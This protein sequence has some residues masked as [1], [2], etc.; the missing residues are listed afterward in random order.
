MNYFGKHAQVDAL[1]VRPVVL[2]KGRTVAALYGLGNV[3]DERLYRAFVEK[4]V[5]MMQPVLDGGV[6]CSLA[7]IRI[8]R[9]TRSPHRRAGRGAVQRVDAAPES[10]PAQRQ[11]LRVG[12]HAARVPQLCHMGSR[13]RSTCPFARQMARFSAFCFAQ[14]MPSPQAVAGRDFYV[15]QPGSSVATSLVEGEP[16]DRRCL[17]ANASLFPSQASRKR[18]TR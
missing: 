9:S 14:C 7:A 12:A 17:F 1:A 13:T 18:S 2:R 10:R 3:R 5:A 4:R 16:I 11:G 8:A 15:A 6:S